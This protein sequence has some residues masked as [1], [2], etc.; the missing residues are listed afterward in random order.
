MKTIV[1][2]EPHTAV[3]SDVTQPQLREGQVL[4]RVA[5]VGICMS[6]VEILNG[7]HPGIK[8]PIIPGHEWCGTVVRVGSGVGRLKGGERVVVEGHNFCG[9]CFWCRRGETHLCAAY[10]E[11]GFTM[12]GA[13]SEYVAVRSDLAHPIAEGLSFEKAA[14]TEPA[15]CAGHGMLRASV[16]PGDDVV[17]IGPGTIGLLGVGWAR[18]LGARHIVVIGRRRANEAVARAMGATHY[19]TVKDEALVLVR[20]LT[21][22]RG[23]DVVFEAAGNETVIPL[24]LDLARPGGT[25]SLVGIAGAGRKIPFESDAFCLK[26]LRVHGILAY[27]SAIFV[28][29][30]RL[31][32]SGLLNVELLITHRFPLKDYALA[33]ELLQSRRDPVIK[34]LLA[35]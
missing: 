23:A 26:D 21:D 10:S 30:L 31:I 3:F 27:R 29:T 13:Y 32:E 1:I 20:D 14:L 35:P 11:F 7:T 19:L 6:D 17:I 4:V 2:K 18:L 8:Y 33:F 9:S 24:A 5:S 28:R 16:Q 12:P 22:G 15:A 25:V 34:I